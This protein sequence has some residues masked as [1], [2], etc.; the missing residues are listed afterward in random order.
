MLGKLRF[1]SFVPHVARAPAIVL[2]I[3][4]IIFIYS[5]VTS[6]SAPASSASAPAA[7]NSPEAMGREQS[8]D[9]FHPA[10]KKGGKVSNNHHQQ[11]IETVKNL[12]RDAAGCVDKI[13]RAE[14]SSQQET[15]IR[16]GLTLIESAKLI[17]Q[18]N[19]AK[20]AAVSGINVSK[21]ESYLRHADYQMSQATT[22]NED[23]E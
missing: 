2:L 14:T 19:Y 6:A 13:A 4:L 5:R 21:L 3:V 8:G 20:W 12:L 22:Q 17:S 23:D 16:E 11:R 7:A 15:H 18:E 9:H 1:L 10:A